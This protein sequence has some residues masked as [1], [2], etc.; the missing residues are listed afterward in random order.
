MH[1]NISTWRASA[2]MWFPG[3]AVYANMKGWG[4]SSIPESLLIIVESYN[5]SSNSD[6]CSSI[7]STLTGSGIT[8]HAYRDDDHIAHY[9]DLGKGTL[10]NYTGNI[11]LKLETNGL[12]PL[13]IRPLQFRHNERNCVSNYRRLDCLLNRLFRHQTSKLR[14]NGLCEGIHRWP[15]QRASNAENISQIA[16]LYLVLRTDIFFRCGLYFF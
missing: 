9:E 7:G 14:A 12:L 2:F 3:Q 11:T 4:S 8:S 13:L 5:Y 16:F 1:I 6:T 15:S 10:H